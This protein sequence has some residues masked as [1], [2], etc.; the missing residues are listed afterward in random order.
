MAEPRF[1]PDLLNRRAERRAKRR[2]DRFR[3]FFS[4]VFSIL[5][6][7]FLIWLITGAVSRTRNAGSPLATATA[8]EP[9]LKAYQTLYEAL[10]VTPTRTATPTLTA[11]VPTATESPL[12]TETG[13][14]TPTMTATATAR[15]GTKAPDGGKPRP[16]AET[17]AALTPEIDYPFKVLGEPGAINA[18]MIYQNSDCSWMGVAG[19]VTD[20]KGDP[21]VGYFV[22]VGGFADGEVRE[23]MSGLFEIYGPS[24]YEI[25]LARPVQRI[26]G[27]LWIQL[28]NSDRKPVSK[29]VFFEPS[30]SCER[31]LILINFQKD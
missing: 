11:T 13:T 23:T 21:L 16:A 8:A 5:A 2:R 19:L 28:Y 25:T 22:Q 24:G 3:R 26:E 20:L 27:P 15:I 12:P 30:E 14:P 1:D 18:N 17:P 10:F 4:I 7:A 6:V 31:S 29:R 9:Q